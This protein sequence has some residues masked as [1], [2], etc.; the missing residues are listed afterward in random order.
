MR[1]AM[2]VFVTIVTLNS[3]A[4]SSAS[5]L[6]RT[7]GQSFYTGKSQEIIAKKNPKKPKG[8]PYR[9]SGRREFM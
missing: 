7:I 6:Y 5:T 4:F 1:T 8:T 9:G 3:L 2:T